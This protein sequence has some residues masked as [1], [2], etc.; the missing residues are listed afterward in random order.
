VNAGHATMLVESLQD[1][2][3]EPLLM[4]RLDPAQSEQAATILR[5]G[6]W[7]SGPFQLS[8]GPP[9]MILVALD[10]LPLAPGIK[11]R[12]AH[13]ALDNAKIVMAKVAARNLGN[14]ALPKAEHYNSLHSTD[15]SAQAW[16]LVR[17][18]L[19]NHEQALRDAAE[20]MQHDFATDGAI[21]DLTRHGR[22]AKVELIEF[23]GQRAIRKTF[24]STA[25]RFMEREIEVMEALAAR[26]E[27]PRL[28]ARGHNCIVI[29]HVG[30]GEPL[31]RRPAGKPRP[32][33]LA[34]VR[35]VADFIK[36][37]VALGFDP[38]DLRAPGNMI[39][40]ETGM[41]IIDFEL[42]RRHDPDVP[43]DHCF[44]LCG[45]PPGDAGRP[46]GIAF[47]S[48][49][50]R[51]AW[52]PY[53]LLPLNSFLY[54]PAWLQQMK[55]GANFAT[56]YWQWSSRGLIRRAARHTA[57]L[58]R[59]LTQSRGSKAYQQQPQARPVRPTID[60]PT[61]KIIRSDPRAIKVRSASTI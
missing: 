23:D 28:L 13:P 3:F 22:R 14:A 29:E 20:Q 47:I 50:Y 9:A 52:F 25:L 30:P 15:S 26:P 4:A 59:R 49:P 36:A 11:H 37:S 55:R 12:A 21:E 45:V 18:L 35:Q 42:W 60:P 31:P 61:D 39:F 16:H 6:N 41:K 27:I 43:A 46:R 10:L 57:A 5:G 38:L 48:R 24:K 58:I 40:T 17:Q 7:G 51:D 54:D 2:G 34:Q 1:S 19:G 53:T 44:G 56:A 8:G 33:P 32:L